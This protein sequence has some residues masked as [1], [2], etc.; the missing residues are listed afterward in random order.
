MKNIIFASLLTLSFIGNAQKFPFYQNFEWEKNP[1]LINRGLEDPMYYF[2]EHTVAVEY[3]FDANYGAYNKFETVHYRV[4]LNTDAGVEEFN[5]VYI[6]LEDVFNVLNLKARLIR[7]DGIVNLKPEIEEFYNEDEGEEYYYFPVSGL[8]VGD[9][10]EI[11]YTK[12]MSQLMNGDQFLFQDEYPIFNSSFYM[13]CPTFIKFDFEAYNG[14]PKPEKVDTILQVTQYYAHMDTID[15][16]KSE[17]Y[18]EYYNSIYKIDASASA[19]EDGGM[20][21]KYY[22][23]ERTVKYMNGL[24]NQPIKNGV[25]KK[26]LKQM[27]A[28]GYNKSNSEEENIRILETYIKVKLNYNNQMTDEGVLKTIKN[29]NS[30]G[31]GLIRLYK[32]FFDVAGIEYEYGYTSDR[33]DTYFSDKIESDYFLQNMIFYFPDVNLYMA[34]LDFKSRLGFLPSSWIPNNAMLMSESK[35]GERKSTYAVSA[36]PAVDYKKNVDSTVIKIELAENL[37]DMNIKIEV[38]LTGYGAGAVQ[39]FYYAYS[40]ER[41]K[42]KLKDI[43]NVLGSRSVYK[44]TEH[45]NV[46]PEDAFIKPLIVKGEVTQL[47]THLLDKAGDKT[48][49]KLGNIF[50]DGIDLKEVINRKSDFTFKNAQKYVKTVEFSFPE[51]MKVT[52]MVGVSEFKNLVDLDGFLMSSMISIDGN[53]LTYTKKTS[54]MK[55]R[56]SL[57]DKAKMLEVFKFYSSNANMNIIL[58]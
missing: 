52:S 46:S 1:V 34:P 5:K 6:S 33:Y 10:L 14:F 55:Q 37:V 15:A 36:I 13:I 21:E 40:P 24:Y 53:K 22:P 54:Y 29:K 16:F 31:T 17:Y 11:I 7:E 44:V 20:F 58:E 51:G 26:I 8:K 3:I 2:N 41:K 27:Y 43:L 18:S 39:S 28:V 48:I 38:Y 12:K 50:G 57:E 47:A 23:Y 30:S 45:H 56:Y 19:I 42:E 32:A 4:F 25:K 9:E 49:F 35:T